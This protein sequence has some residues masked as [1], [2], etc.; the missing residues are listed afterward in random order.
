[1]VGAIVTAMNDEVRDHLDFWGS[2]LGGAAA[3]AVAFLV[4][5]ASELLA[6]FIVIAVPAVAVFIR[7]V[8]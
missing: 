5:G 6:G 2:A 8:F 7:E 4:F 3:G 1:M